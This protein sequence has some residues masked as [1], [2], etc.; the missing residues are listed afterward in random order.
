RRGYYN[1]GRVPQPAVNLLPEAAMTPSKALRF[2][3][4]FVLVM[5][6]VLA[7]TPPTIPA[8]PAS[9]AKYGVT[10][11][12]D[13]MVPMRD[14]VKLATD[15]YLPTVDGVAIQEKLPTIL[16]R[17]PYDKQRAA[18]VNSAHYYSARGYAVVIQDTRGRFKSEGVWHMLTDDGRDGSDVCEWIGRQPWSNGKVGMIGTSY[19]GGSQHAVA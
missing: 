2:W 6:A 8:Q 7:L 3:A 11:L 10:V 13:V 16:E 5:A 4:T 15:V 17:T 18:D 1:R 14:G 12:R 9:D 19:V